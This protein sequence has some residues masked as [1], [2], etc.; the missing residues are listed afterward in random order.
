MGSEDH[1]T[2]VYHRTAYLPDVRAPKLSRAMT[3]VG[4]DVKG[5]YRQLVYN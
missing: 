5:H 4:V 3:K 1:F 2:W